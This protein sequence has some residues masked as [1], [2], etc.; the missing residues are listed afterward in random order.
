MKT[1]L[2]KHFTFIDLFSGIGGFNQAMSSLGGK[3]VFASEINKYA[4]ETYYCNYGM[5][6]N[7]DITKINPYDVPQHDVL[8]AGFPCQSFSKAGKQD[9]F[10]DSRG[11]LFFDI[12]RILRNHIKRYG[13]PSFLCLENVR[14]LVTHDKGRTWKV[15]YHE[16]DDLGYNIVEK[17]IFVSP[18]YLGVPQLRERAIILGVRK[19][20][21]SKK[22]K[23]TIEKKSHNVCDCKKILDE[24]VNPKYMLSAYEI[25]VLDMWDE[26]IKGIENKTIGF[27]VWSDDF[28]KKRDTRKFPN[29]KKDFIKKNCELYAL[30]KTFIDSWYKKYDKMSWI[31]NSAHRKF[32]WQ[33]GDHMNSVYDGIIQFRTSGI[34]VKRPTE[35]PALVAMVHVPI[36]GFK[37]RYIT[38]VEAQRLQ[39]FPSKFICSP[40]DHEAYK[41]FGNAVNVKVIK[42]TFKKFVDEVEE[43]LDE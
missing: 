7:H 24:H 37:G 16:L 43:N 40:N 33:A 21:Y 31:T 41:Q 23:T 42:T 9:G 12:I 25:K 26:F 22:I 27:P 38:P 15:I 14:N 34:R 28:F 29:W 30:N 35:F 39:S 5:D 3:C 20:I 10:D 4:I 19:D 1:I 36:V 18:Y 8:C 11:T 17:P 2:P 32:E 13:G 6:S